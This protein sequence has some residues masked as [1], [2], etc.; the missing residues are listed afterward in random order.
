MMVLHDRWK[1]PPLLVG[2]TWHQLITLYT[3]FYVERL[4]RWLVLQFVEKVE[5]NFF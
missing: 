2:S 4:M 3:M 5:P 1:V